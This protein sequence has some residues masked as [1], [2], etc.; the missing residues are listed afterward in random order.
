MIIEKNMEN[1][2]ISPTELAK[3]IDHTLL[4]PEASIADIEQICAEAI[5]FG[6]ASVCVNPCYIKHV[7]K[8]LENQSPKVCGVVGFPLGASHSRIKQ[9]EAQ[10][11]IDDGAQELDMVI[12]LSAALASDYDYVTNDI[13]TVLHACRQANHKVLLKIILEMRVL[14]SD[15]KLRMC[16]IANDLGAD[17]I[18][19]ST[20]LHPAG[21]ATIDDVKFMH[22]HRGSCK[23]KASGGIRDLTT[24]KT[25]L[26]AG[27]DRIGTSSGHAIIQQLIEYQKT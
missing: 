9:A 19:T 5:Q 11:N 4:K 25:M 21:G 27:A 24:T 16:N 2:K 3:K 10:Q 14:T 23:V 15:N 7:A 8:L 12:N 26:L 1:S 20:G 6:F 13:K 18:K 17:F 22:Q